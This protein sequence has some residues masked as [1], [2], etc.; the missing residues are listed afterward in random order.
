MSEFKFIFKS[1]SIISLFGE[2]FSKPFNLQF[3]L[4]LSEFMVF[5][6]PTSILQNL[7]TSSDNVHE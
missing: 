7:R 2:N 1:L 4:G 5:S 3:N 6:I